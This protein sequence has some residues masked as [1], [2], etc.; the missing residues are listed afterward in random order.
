MMK[1]E[2]D[3][4]LMKNIARKKQMESILEQQANKLAEIYGEINKLENN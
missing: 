2:I 3:E 1:V 4:Q